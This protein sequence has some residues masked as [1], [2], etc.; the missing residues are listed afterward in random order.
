MFIL[1]RIDA[2]KYRCIL[3]WKD[4]LT[5][6]VALADDVKV[7]VIRRRTDADAE[8]LSLPSHYVE[9]I[10]MFNMDSFVAGVGWLGNHLALLVVPKNN[11]LLGKGQRPQMKLVEPLQESYHEISADVLS[12]RG[13]QDYSCREYQLGIV[14]LFVSYLFSFIITLCLIYRKSGRRGAILYRQPKRRCASK[15]TKSRWSRPMANGTSVNSRQKL[16]CFIFKMIFFLI[17][18][19]NMKRRCK[20][21]LGLMLESLNAIHFFK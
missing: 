21:S 8:R 14:F 6:V 3:Y 10:S 11:D 18:T 4:D 2:D 12:I 1:C 20:L 16:S 5:L 7:C 17:W 15:T 19:V 13:F 9:I